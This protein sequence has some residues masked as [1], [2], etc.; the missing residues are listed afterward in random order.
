MTPELEAGIGYVLL[1]V[2][3]IWIAVLFGARAWRKCSTS[4]EKRMAEWKRS[5]E[6]KIRAD[7]EIGAAEWKRS[8][9]ATIRA[10]AESVGAARATAELAKQVTSQYPPD[11]SLLVLGVSGP[12]DCVIIGQNTRVEFT[13]SVINCAPFPVALSCVTAQWTLSSSDNVCEAVCVR[14]TRERREGLE[15]IDPGKVK[16]V[17]LQDET[18]VERFHIEKLKGCLR[19]LSVTG[20]FIAST[21]PETPGAKGAFGPTSCWIPVKE[22]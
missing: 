3:I 1:A 5:T 20:A 15:W 2:S 22:R 18:T 13:L 16:D 19:R 7:L 8:T 6:E 12:D 4:A 17:H 21:S 11:R 9:G 14:G 10:E